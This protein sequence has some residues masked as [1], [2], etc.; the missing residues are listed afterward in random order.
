[1]LV[2]YLLITNQ[3]IRCEGFYLQN[4]KQYAY[5]LILIQQLDN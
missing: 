1:M 3:N 4:T 5:F 2:L